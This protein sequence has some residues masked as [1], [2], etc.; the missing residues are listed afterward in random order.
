MSDPQIPEL[1]CNCPETYL[2]GYDAGY[3]QA[4]RDTDQAK[5]AGYLASAKEALEIEEAREQERA[6]QIELARGDVETARERYDA[7]R[8]RAMELVGLVCLNY[9]SKEWRHNA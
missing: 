8:R 5:C 1:C 9:H 7:T 4:E 6:R 3:E 2:K